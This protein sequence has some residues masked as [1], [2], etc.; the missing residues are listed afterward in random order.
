MILR[1]PSKDHITLR[2]NLKDIPDSWRQFI[3]PRIE[4]PSKNSM[5]FPCW[6]WQGAIGTSGE[7]VMMWRNPMKDFQRENVP[8]KIVIA[9]LF[10]P[11]FKRNV[12]HVYHECGAK[13]CLHPAHFL[14]TNLHPS[15]ITLDRFVAK[16][17]ISIKNY[18]QQLLRADAEQE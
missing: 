8:V 16:K 14:V 1:L 7:P 5:H 17:K 13:N 2:T 10:W 12:H 18:Q 6:L 9:E 15:Q 4:R 11:G 3:E